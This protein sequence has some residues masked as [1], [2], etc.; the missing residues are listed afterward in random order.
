HRLWRRHRPRYRHRVF[1]DRAQRGK[2]APGQWGRRGSRN[3]RCP[4]RVRRIT[5][6][7]TKCPPVRRAFFCAILAPA[8]RLL[9]PTPTDVQLHRRDTL[10]MY[11]SPL[12]NVGVAPS[13]PEVPETGAASALPP[14]ALAVHQSRLLEPA[15][16][17]APLQDAL[18]ALTAT[19]T[20][21]DPDVRA[22]VVVT[23]P[24]GGPA[25][26]YAA[27]LPASFIEHMRRPLAADADDATTCAAAM[28]QGARVYCTD[29]AH[30]DQWSPQWRAACL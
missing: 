19:A 24:A 20:D 18:L 16:T 14:A 17:G 2:P 25:E 4:G 27:H 1:Q 6:P 3:R 23:A 13:Q 10:S 5:P 8:R 11:K 22:A 29:I 12:S 7:P 15:A 28:R 30:D 21:L 26:A 9:A